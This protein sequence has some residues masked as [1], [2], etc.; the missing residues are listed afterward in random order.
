MHK[1]PIL[2]DPTLPEPKKY[3]GN[4][5]YTEEQIAQ[6]LL[7]EKGLQY[8]AAEKLGMFPSHLVERIK[9]SPYLQKIRDIAKERR[10]DVA[11]RSLSNM[12]EREE[13]GAV[14]WTLKTIGKSRGYTE[15][16]EISVSPETAQ[17]FEN[18]MKFLEESRNKSS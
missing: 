12:T 3:S 8:L 4:V 6:A 16:T 2:K 5:T 18:M 15:T 9:V 7:D 11:E 10:I 1:D 17:Q 14:V 13:L